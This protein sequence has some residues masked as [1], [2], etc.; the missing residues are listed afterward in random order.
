MNVGEGG[1]TSQSGEIGVLNLVRSRLL[2]RTDT[3]VV[4]DVGANSGQFAVS[5]LQI[6]GDAV[7][8]WS[9]EPC[10]ASF[11]ELQKTLSAR[12][13][14]T[15]VN[16]ALGSREGEVKM[17][18]PQP[19]SLLASVYHRSIRWEDDVSQET[20]QC[21]TIDG[22]CSKNAIQRIHFLKVDVEGH[23][24]EVLRGAT[25]LLERDRIDFIQF[26]VSDAHIEARVFFR[27]FYELLNAKYQ[28][29]RVLKNGLAHISEYR[30]ELEVFKNA[31]NYLAVRKT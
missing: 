26:E 25:S 23:E 31:T 13:N 19:G 21:R 16:A 27:D 4:F 12:S 3:P 9:F 18:S 22:Y 28:I 6:F 7:K 14:V 30:T 15:L 29:H 17:F 11:A 2:E 1:R 5:V 10:R 20:A 24:L 8:L